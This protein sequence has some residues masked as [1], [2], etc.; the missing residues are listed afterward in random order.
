MKDNIDSLPPVSGYFSTGCTILD[1]AI[2]DRLPG[3]FGVGRISHVYGPESTSKSIISLEPL[4]SAQ[5]QGGIATLVDTEGTFDSKRAEMLFGIDI[6]K[7][8]YLSPRSESIIKDD[9]TDN[10]TIESLFK[11]IIEPTLRD[12]KPDTLN[13]ISIDSLSAISSEHEMD[14]KDPYGAS[15]AKALSASFRKTIWKLCQKNLSL[16]FVDQTRQDIGGSF[17]KKYIY[18][19]GEALK[20]YASTRVLLTPGGKIE[21]AHKKIMG[22]TINFKVDKNKIAPPYREG[23]FDILF[24]YGIDNISSSLKFLQENRSDVTKGWHQFD[25]KKLRFNDMINYIEENRLED[26]LEATVYGLW[27]QLYLPSERKKRLR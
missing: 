16:I 10:I 26:E 19:G 12:C 21:N 7:L 2:A 23:S 6:A 18:S 22:V 11:N 9:T 3:G 27:K 24:D 14:E 5:R 17:I 13:V 20:F 8:I 25:G 15:R 1:L 4:G